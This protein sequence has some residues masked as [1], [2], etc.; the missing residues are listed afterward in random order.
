MSERPQRD[1]LVRIFICDDVAELRTLIRLALEVDRRLKVVGDAGDGRTAVQTICE[2][3][4]DIVVLD[5]SLP[6]LDGL[7]AI[8]LIHACSPL[9]KILVFSGFAEERM[10][11]RVL[12]LDAAGYVQKGQPLSELR[13]TLLELAE[14]A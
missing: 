3:K 4:P 6:G 13:Q 7:E 11:A 8:P 5:L 2:I 14:L 1:R 12:A 9:A 10:A